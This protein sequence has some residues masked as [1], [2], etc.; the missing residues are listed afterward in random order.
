MIEFIT[1]NV[2]VFLDD[3]PTR[4]KEYTTKAIRARGTVRR[5]LLDHLIDL[6]A[7]EGSR[8]EAWSPSFVDSPQTKTHAGVTGA[9]QSFFVRLKEDILFP[10]MKMNERVVRQSKRGNVVSTKPFSCHS[11]NKFCVAISKLEVSDSTTLLLVHF[12]AVHQMKKVSFQNHPK[13]SFWD[14]E[15]PSFLQ[16]INLQEGFVAVFN[17]DR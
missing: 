9:S 3:W 2:K 8:H 12:F 17:K 15:S 16:S 11:V 13:V 1:Q 6:L 10:N 14:R 4:F 7:S 5:R